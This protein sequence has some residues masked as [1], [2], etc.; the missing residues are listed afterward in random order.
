[1]VK[2]GKRDSTAIAPGMEKPA[3]DAAQEPILDDVDELLNCID[4]EPVVQQEEDEVLDIL[5]DAEG[6]ESPSIPDSSNDA[7][8]VPWL[9]RYET[10]S[11]LIGQLEDTLRMME[12]EG[13]NLTEAWE[14]A[15]TA[16]SLLESADV[17]QALIFANRS[18]N[19]AR[20]VHRMGSSGAA[21]S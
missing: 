18:F 16:R 15:N 14:M 9:D 3:S 6:I 11:H 4:C 17:V 10:T 19:M 1:V 12:E 13:V 2:A 21:A 8:P 7:G 5:D 20:Q